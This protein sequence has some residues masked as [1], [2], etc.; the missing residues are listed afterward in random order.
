MSEIG[1]LFKKSSYRYGSVVS[2]LFFMSWGIWWSFF[3]IWLTS[4]AGGLELSG[5][6]VGLVYSVNGA[7][8]LVLMFVYGTIQDKLYLRRGLVTVV[9]VVMAFIGP[10]AQF[11]YFPLLK[12]NL[13]LGAIIGGIVLSAGFIGSAS[14]MDAYVERISRSYGFEFG[15]ARMWGSFGYAIVALIAG[16]LFTINPFFNFWIGSVL[17]LVLLAVLRFWKIGAGETKNKVP[18]TPSFGEMLALL[19]DSKVWAVIGFVFLSFTFY[20]V[21]DQQMFP[22][23]YTS[24]FANEATG[25]QMY[26]TLN[27]VQV[28]LEAAMMGLI[29]LLLRKVGARN[30]LLLGVLF[31]FIRIGMCSVFDSAI[32]ISFTKLLHAVE[33]PL[34]VLGIFRYF[35]I[36]FNPALSATLYLVAWNI[37]QQIGTIILSNP[38]GRLRDAIGYQPTFAV[39]SGI[40]GLAAIFA[41]VFLKKDSESVY[42]DPDIL[43]SAEAAK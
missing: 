37:A 12:S 28:F 5:A 13:L 40:A 25:Q 6:Q 22:D 1:K 7:F 35:A 31:M 38:L 24:L 30:C 32:L 36:H 16:F 11:V 15:Q 27:S 43:P 9:G 41:F 10:F 34:F 23:F 42:Q 14:L 39:I 3:Q 18:A 2:M 8:T 33:V 19:K 20:T 26:G 21:F 29:P 17:G 4:S